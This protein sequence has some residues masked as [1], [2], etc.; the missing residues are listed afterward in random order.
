M[1][2]T[3]VLTNASQVKEA[4][5]HFEP[6]YVLKASGL[7]A[8]KGVWIGD[9]ISE[10]ETFA[11]DVLKS[12][13]SLVIE[14]FLKGEELSFFAMVSGERFLVLGAAQDHKR[15]LENDRGPNTGG[16]GAYSPVPILDANLEA[17]IISKILVPTIEGLKADGI[18]Y[19]GFIFLG[20][21]IVSGEPF[22]LEY[23][24]RLGDP[25]TQALLLRLKSPLVSLAESLRGSNPAKAEL[26]HDVSLN[27]VVAAAGYPDQPKQGFTIEGLESCP[28][29][30]IVFHSGT[31]RV[32]S[33]WTA[34]GGR[35]FSVN[36]TQKNLFDCQ[37]KVYP[38]IESLPF[39]KDVTYRR[40]I[41]VKAYT[42]LL[43][44]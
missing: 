9:K 8:G 20:M 43:G 44:R 34:Q 31:K 17:K 28:K 41:A 22:L 25:E 12:H 27:V 42:H 14:E 37:Q 26:S 15:L 4:L 23:N 29:D 40:D 36:T 21:M 11:A 5:K 30:C 32:G 6:P 1:A 35:L 19:R 3:R 2:R 18:F 24:C 33:N 39:L 10:A 7:A 16:M 38:W 13:P